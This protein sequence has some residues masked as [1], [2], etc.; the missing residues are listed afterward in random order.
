MFL[1][2][3]TANNINGILA[4]SRRFYCAV[5]STFVLHKTIWQKTSRYKNFIHKPPLSKQITLTVYVAIWGRYELTLEDG[6]NGFE[7]KLSSVKFQTVY[8]R[9]TW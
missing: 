8:Y 3:L 4:Q 2:L 1:H 9:V 5:Y 6:K 7:A